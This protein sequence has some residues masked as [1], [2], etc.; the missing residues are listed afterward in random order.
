MDVLGG[1]EAGTGITVEQR[2]QM[3]RDGAAEAST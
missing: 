3:V 2:P 1:A